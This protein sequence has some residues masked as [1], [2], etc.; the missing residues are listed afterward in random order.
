MLRSTWILALALSVTPL[1]TSC[2]ENSERQRSA[3]EIAF[4]AEGGVYVAGM[5]DAGADRIVGTS[6]DFT[7]AG[8]VAI[9]VNNRSYNQFISAP[10]TGPFSHFHVTDVAVEWRSTGASPLSELAPFNYAG[11]YD[12]T[13]PQ[14]EQITFN[15]MV[16]PFNMKQSTYFQDLLGTALSGPAYSPQVPSFSAS[17]HVTL[18]GHESGSTREY[19]VEGSVIVEFIGV[20]VQ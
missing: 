19:E 3:V 12:V 1:L 16:V 7:P 5:L 10:D 13:I 11:G 20:I 8:H 15:V 14:G 17:A 2:E 9:T 6:D 4:V 18:T